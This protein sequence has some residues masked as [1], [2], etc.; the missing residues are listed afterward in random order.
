LGFVIFLFLIVG[1]D[2]RVDNGNVSTKLNSLEN[3]FGV[4][5]PTNYTNACGGSL[6]GDR[7]IADIV[8]KMEVKDSTFLL[9]QQSIAGKLQENH[10]SAPKD[11]KLEGYFPWWDCS[12]YPARRVFVYSNDSNDPRGHLYVWAIETNGIH[13]MYIHGMPK[14]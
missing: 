7:G 12:I 11:S 5:W 13:T 2:F 10:N 9:W 1:C 4:Q 6:V 8:V 3:Q 14:N